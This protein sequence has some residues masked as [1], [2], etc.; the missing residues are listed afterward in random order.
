MAGGQAWRDAARRPL[1]VWRGRARA[2]RTDVVALALAVRD[3]RVPWYAKAVAVCVVA[4]ALSPLDLIP[5]FI[6]VLG[7]LDDLV[8]VPLGI[9]LVRRLVPADILAAHRAAAASVPALPASRV[10]A[11]VVVALWGLALAAVAVVVLRHLG[12]TVAGVD[13][14]IPREASA[15]S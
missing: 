1:R 10:G 14:I 7:V 4:Y 15:P 3:P 13:I 9:V 11:A 8:V 6:P 2:L 5:D 12:V